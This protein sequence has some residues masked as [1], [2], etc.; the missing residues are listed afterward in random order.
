M[1]TSRIEHPLKRRQFYYECIRYATTGALG[2]TGALATFLPLGVYLFK[3]CQPHGYGLVAAHLKVYNLGS[4]LLLAIPLTI[5][6][7]ILLGRLVTAPFIL[8]RDKP[9]AAA[10]PSLSVDASSIVI[11]FGKGESEL[12]DETGEYYSPDLLSFTNVGPVAAT[13]VTLRPIT[14]MGRSFE[15]PP[16]PVLY[17]NGPAVDVP[18]EGLEYR[19]WKVRGT[20]PRPQTG[21]RELPIRIKL[22][23][24][25]DTWTQREGILREYALT[26]Y[27][28]G[29][30]IKLIDPDDPP[31]WTDLNALNGAAHI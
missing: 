7:L 13:N 8:Y 9:S 23:L 24:D 29:I 10:S 3:M 11:A 30:S 31:D 12:D 15:V 4:E 14:I 16:I 2:M 6:A 18:V 22:T 21:E 19:L 27:S 5:G 17:S 28:H 25:A 26:Q 20:M 1:H